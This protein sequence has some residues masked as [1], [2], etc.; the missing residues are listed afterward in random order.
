MV[1]ALSEIRGFNNLDYISIWFY[2]G[3]KYIENSV[4]KYAFVSTNSICQGEQVGLLWSDI[5]KY[6]LEINFAHTSFKWTNN[7]KYNAGVTC[8]V[9]GVSKKS[10]KEKLIY[11]V[12]KIKKTN[13]INAYL[14]KGSNVIVKSRS[15]SLSKFPVLSFGSMPN[16]NGALILD[17]Y[18]KEKL[19]ADYPE[20][21]IFIRKFLGSQE[22]I[23]GEERYCLWIEDNMI[24]KAN[25]VEPIRERIDRVYRERAKSKR[26]PTQKLARFPYRFG[27]IRYKPTHS[28]IIPRVSSE[29]R[30]YIPM[31]FLDKNIVVSD[32]AFALYDAQM[33]L[34]GILTSKIH[35]AWVRAVGGS[36]ETRIRYSATLCYN[37][38]PFP[39][40]SEAK[41]KEIEAL[42][43]EVLLTREHHTEKTLAEMYDPDKMPQ[44]LRDAHHAL[45]VAVDSC[46]PGAPFK[47]DEERLEVLFKMYEKMSR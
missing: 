7:A 27:E 5:F 46:Y 33:W 9:I 43:E 22:F 4:A 45:D 6:N 23:R 8:V 39:T 30:E 14:T 2:L 3:A 32:S 40:I 26:I 47:S 12:N 36:L 31:G 18:E 19:I 10:N 15:K 16:D 42:A 13:Y 34:F 11:D 25:K 24:D 38:F 21:E 1:Y 20:A 29:R 28:I 35:N 17:R 37:T 41:K 44:D